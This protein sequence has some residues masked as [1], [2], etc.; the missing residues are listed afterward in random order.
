MN[1]W[2]GYPEFLRFLSRRFQRFSS[3]RRR[4]RSK[5]RISVAKHCGQTFKRRKSKREGV[6]DTGSFV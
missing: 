4:R 5:E 1:M 2:A 6:G 3:K